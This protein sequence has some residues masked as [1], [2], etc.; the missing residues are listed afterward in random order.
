MIGKVRKE[1]YQ[2]KSHKLLKFVTFRTGTSEKERKLILLTFYKKKQISQKMRPNFLP[3]TGGKNF[4]GPG[5][6]GKEKQ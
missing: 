1:P 2:N 5:N 3:R 6:T 4:P